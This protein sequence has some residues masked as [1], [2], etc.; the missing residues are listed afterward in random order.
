MLS[1]MARNGVAFT[2]TD[3]AKI[4]AERHRLRARIA[5]MIRHHPDRPDLIA[6]EQSVLR[7]LGL[8]VRIRRAIETP[9]GLTPLQVE[10]LVSLLRSAQ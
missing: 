8:E 3:P 9:P 7:V 6:E 4:L 1:G 2:S 10:Q 5:A